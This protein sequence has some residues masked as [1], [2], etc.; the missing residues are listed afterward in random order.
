MKLNVLNTSAL[1]GLILASSSML[2]PARAFTPAENCQISAAKVT[3]W[4]KPY[5]VPAYSCNAEGVHFVV[6]DVSAWTTHEE[7]I[8]HDF[9]VYLHSDTQ[10]GT[11]V[12]FAT[13]DYSNYVADGY[14]E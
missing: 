1:T 14:L 13:G 8:G 5:K 9:E 7:A 12:Y 4:G 10:T 3:I 11:P 2:L 6:I